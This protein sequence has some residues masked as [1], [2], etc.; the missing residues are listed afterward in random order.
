MA[1]TKSTKSQTGDRPRSNLKQA[2]PAWVAVD[3]YFEDLLAPADAKLEAALAANQAAELPAIDVS[4]LQGKFLHLLVQLTQARRVLEIGTLG[5]YSTIWIARALPEGG[6]IVTLEFNPK[7]A[8]VARKN[9]EHAGLLDRVDIRVGRALDSLPVLESS[10][11]GPFDLVFV[12]ADKRSN[13]QYLEWALK[14]SRPGSL[15]FVDNVV[16]D[17]KVV[18]ADSTDPDIQGTRRMMEMLAA[19]PR[20][21][22]TALQSVGIK[23]YD[24]FV[25][26]IVQR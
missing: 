20:L 2:E 15:I 24:G 11:A 7:H 1:A 10:G 18:D 26:A 5:G 8:E 3:R 25:L 19:E 9:L 6:R 23:G 21:S 22:A 4:P 12:D 13:P 17:G 14:L 16:R